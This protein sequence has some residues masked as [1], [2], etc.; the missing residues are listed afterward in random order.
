MAT[1]SAGLLVYR[2]R[3]SRLEVFLAH[4]GGPF[5]KN[6]DTGAWSIPKG[7]VKPGE[8]P[9]AAA[10]REFEEETG[11]RLSG[12]FQPLGNVQQKGG[13]IVAAWACAGEIDPNSVCS[14][15]A[16]IEWPPRSG[17][18]IEVP[19]IDRCDWFELATAKE[20]INPA[21][22]EFL[23]RLSAMLEASH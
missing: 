19:E 17:R 16:C 6:R 18:Q 11:M 14:N 22:A 13:K 8:D 15:V 23:V 20:K 1:L 4:P 12:P 2:R 10:C 9:L 21:Q 3:N 7:L 5:W